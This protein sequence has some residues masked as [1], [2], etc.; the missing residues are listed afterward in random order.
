MARVSCTTLVSALM[1]AAFFAVSA[2][3]ET[4][5]CKLA[6]EFCGGIAAFQCCDGYECKFEGDFP[7]AGGKCIKSCPKSGQMCGGFA[8]I[9]CCDG[10]ECVI[11]DKHIADASGI[12]KKR[13][14]CQRAGQN[15]GG[16]TRFPLECCKGFK[17]V[18]KN[19]EIADIGGTCQRIY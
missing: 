1:L 5:T 19:P 10:Y 9:Q 18:L 11:K 13:P 7:D 3:E 14:S 6:D 12:C 2:A 8:G 4:R 17:C 16:F 15:C